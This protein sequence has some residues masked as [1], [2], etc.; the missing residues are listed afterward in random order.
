[1]KWVFLVLVSLM[2]SVTF[3]HIGQFS[4]Y[5]YTID[6]TYNKLNDAEAAVI[7]GKGTERPGSGIYNE[8]FDTG[9]YVCRQCET[10]LYLSRTKF[11]SGCGWPSFDAEIP[12]SVLHKPDQ[13]GRRTEILCQHCQGHLGHVFTGEQF[14]PKNTRH[15][16]NSISLKFIGVS[17][18]LTE[19]KKGHPR[20]GAAVLAGGCF[21]GVEYL[22][23]NISG[24]LATQ[25]GYAGGTLEN[26]SYQQVCNGNTGHAE[27]LCVIFDK[28]KIDYA[29][30][31][32]VFFEI[33]DPTQAMRQGPD[34]GSQY[35]S[36]IFYLLDDE[37]EVAS[38]VKDEL[39][40]LGFDV[41]TQITPLTTFWPAEDYHQQY[42]E[43]KGGEPYCHMRVKRFE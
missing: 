14:T 11:H 17:A 18:L 27:V 40:A 20:Y 33:H 22:F 12:G 25:V 19:A 2:C 21:W 28:S 16:V 26:P 38:R 23:A 6:M 3:F 4:T 5:D 41:V 43:K 37:R 24:V 42:Y 31:L 36:E 13:D 15:C 32:R 35:R 34:V 7:L 39:I 8:H 1:M 10:P 9:I 30:I 29:A